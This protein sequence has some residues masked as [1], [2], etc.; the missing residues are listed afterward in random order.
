MWQSTNIGPKSLVSDSHFTKFK[1]KYSSKGNNPTISIVS[2]QYQTAFVDFLPVGWLF[3]TELW[4][5]REQHFQNGLCPAVRRDQYKNLK[6]TILY[7]VAPLSL[8]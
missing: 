2:E 5:N 6:L 4:I 3:Y 1:G 7:Y 8:L